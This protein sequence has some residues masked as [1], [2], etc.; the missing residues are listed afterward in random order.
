MNRIFKAFFVL[1]S[2][3]G[4]ACIFCNAPEVYSQLK[5]Y[6]SKYKTKWEKDF[7]VIEISSSVDDEKQKAYVFFASKANRPLIVS[8]H[9]WSGDYTSYDPLAKFAKENDF[10]YIHP[11]F[12]GNNQHP[13]ACCS[14]YAI[15]DVDDSI[16]Y[17]IEN[18]KSLDISNISVV[19]ISGGGMMS[20][21]MYFKSKKNI[22]QFISWVPMTNLIEWYKESKLKNNIY[23][24]DIYKCTNSQEGI[25]NT[26]EAQQRSPVFF[27]TNIERFKNSK[28]KI[29]A[30]IHDG[31][32][33][34]V[35]VSH[36]I[37]IYNKILEDIG[38]GEK[39]Y[40]SSKEKN[41][42]MTNEKTTNNT[43]LMISDRKVLLK[44]EY[45]NLSLTIFDGSHEGLIKHNENLLIKD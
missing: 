43:N 34:S 9:Q 18:S 17:M 27:S 42:I 30:G 25:L 40:V 11:N 15:S 21:C 28:L 8:L 20:L 22:K 26:N 41:F 24:N 37:N 4:I 45:L 38:A 32:S 2:I 16:E 3:I 19:G 10:N 33:G 29:F 13:K 7:K 1:M 39:Y 36:S 12:R 6:Y 44:K 5:V 35:P 14:K 23:S 31:Y